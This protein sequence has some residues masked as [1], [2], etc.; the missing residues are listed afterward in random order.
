LD[1]LN[2]D[3]NSFVKE[4]KMLEEQLSEIKDLYNETK[5]MRDDNYTTG[6]KKNYVFLA[7]QSATLNSILSSKTAIITKMNDIKLKIA[8]MEIKQFNSNKSVESEGGEMSA[9][10]K[11]IFNML[12]NSGRNEISKSIMKDE[13]TDDSSEDDSYSKESIDELDNVLDSLDDNIEEDIADE[14]F[15]EKFF[16]DLHKQLD[17]YQIELVV[18]K[19]TNDFIYISKAETDEGSIL[20][21]TYTDKLKELNELLDQ[22]TLLDENEDETEIST[23]IS[24]VSFELVEIK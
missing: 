6:T 21:K 8:D 4:Y 15:D 17:K 12:L 16:N 2:L 14:T 23:N 24:S 20:D 9:I 3:L 1:Q 10:T 5:K 19:D 7:S 13:N 11:D 18:N 22:I